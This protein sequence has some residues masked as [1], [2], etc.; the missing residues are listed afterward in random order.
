VYRQRGCIC[1]HSSHGLTLD[2]NSILY[3]RPCPIWPLN[4]PKSLGATRR[5]AA[6]G[7]WG[8]PSGRERVQSGKDW[9]CLSLCPLHLCARQPIPGLDSCHLTFLRAAFSNVSQLPM[10]PSILI[11]RPST[12][13]RLAKYQCD[14]PQSTLIRP[15]VPCL[16]M[17]GLSLGS[18]LGPPSPV[19][20]PAWLPGY[21]LIPLRPML[22]L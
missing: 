14:N 10:A 1:G 2:S 12:I 6:G 19:F 3:E 15:S 11:A 13:Y 21:L 9:T 20:P 7:P 8:E 18:V 5:N 4:K 16:S 22:K 17:A